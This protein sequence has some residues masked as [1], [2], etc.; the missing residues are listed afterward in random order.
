MAER[1]LSRVVD[2]PNIQRTGPRYPPGVTAH[3]QIA[4]L[5]TGLSIM[6]FSTP[7]IVAMV[8]YSPV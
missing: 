7:H 4:P 8:R 5:M 2:Y 6:P 3:S 1:A